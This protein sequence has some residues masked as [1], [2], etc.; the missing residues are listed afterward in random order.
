MFAV[1]ALYLLLEKSILID[2]KDAKDMLA[3]AKPD[4]LSRTILGIQACSLVA[5]SAGL[6]S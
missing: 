4:S 3:Q 6:I 5:S 2:T 1:G